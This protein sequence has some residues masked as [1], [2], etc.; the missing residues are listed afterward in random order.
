MAAGRAAAHDVCL[1]HTALVA[2]TRVVARCT[3]GVV[4]D[5]EPMGPAVVVVVKETDWVGALLGASLVIALVFFVVPAAV[6]LLLLW[7][8]WAYV[9]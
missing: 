3:R 6:A 7:G 5:V 4:F 2:R 9:R 8:R 1:R